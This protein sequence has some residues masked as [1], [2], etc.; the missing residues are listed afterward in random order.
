MAYSG[1]KYVGDLALYYIAKKLES[2]EFWID[3][4]K[5]ILAAVL[6][7]IIDTLCD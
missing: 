3:K 7:F 4:F 5:F 6:T 2:G 1:E